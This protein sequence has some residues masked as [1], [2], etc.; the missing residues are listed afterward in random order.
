MKDFSYGED[1]GMFTELR[2]ERLPDMLESIQTQTI[3]PVC[4]NQLTNPEVQSIVYFR[5][6]CVQ[7]WER[8]TVF[9]ANPKLLD[10]SLIWWIISDIEPW[11]MEV[12][13]FIPGYEVLILDC[14][15]RS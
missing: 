1:P 3:N 2:P 15:S 10:L 9:L 14:R 5:H 8:N 11:R 6:F 12:S 7:V 4:L 13:R